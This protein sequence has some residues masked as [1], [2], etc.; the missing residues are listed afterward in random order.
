MATMAEKVFVQE[1]RVYF[2]EEEKYIYSLRVID[3]SGIEVAICKV[4]KEE[5]L[6]LEDAKSELLGQ[7]K[8]NIE[9]YLL[10]SWRDIS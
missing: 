6:S 5:K 8:C 7:L 4:I 3:L 2:S 9:D 1:D 10:E